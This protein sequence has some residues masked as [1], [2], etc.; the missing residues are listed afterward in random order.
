MTFPN[1]PPIDYIALVWVRITRHRCIFFM[2]VIIVCLIIWFV[3]G[4][5][6][7]AI[8]SFLFEI[9]CI[10]SFKNK[11]IYWDNFLVVIFKLM[12]LVFLSFDSVMC[13]LK[14]C[15]V[16]VCAQKSSRFISKMFLSRFYR[17]RK[18]QVHK[19][20]ICRHNHNCTSVK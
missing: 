8:I 5:L 18:V 12:K 2:I 20:I 10:S 4:W 14:L 3:H 1:F 11:K 19:W 6:S 17:Q 15:V 16:L 9:F 13:S 7:L